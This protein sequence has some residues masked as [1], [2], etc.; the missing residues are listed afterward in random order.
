MRLLNRVIAPAG[1]SL[2]CALD[3]GRQ[4]PGLGAGESASAPS[5]HEPAP[6]SFG[7]RLGPVAWVEDGTVT[8]IED[9]RRQLA[10]GVVWHPEESKDRALLETVVERARLLR[11]SSKV[12]RVDAIRGV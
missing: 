6:G 9:A 12:A 8:G 2:I 1:V 11:R 3:H 10:V 4:P 5:N 7:D